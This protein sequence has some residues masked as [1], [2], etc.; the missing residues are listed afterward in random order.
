[1]LLLLLTCLSA[2]VPVSNKTD[3]IFNTSENANIAAKNE[4]VF[5]GIT[6]SEDSGSGEVLAAPQRELSEAYDDGTDDDDIFSVWAVD[7][8]YSIH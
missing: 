4:Q 5:S 2:S 3:V 7:N 8:V 6:E 1:M